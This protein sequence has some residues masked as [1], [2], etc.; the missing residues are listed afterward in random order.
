VQKQHL[1]ASID[2]RCV[3]QD[4]HVVMV[5]ST[6]FPS[7]HDLTVITTTLARQCDTCIWSFSPGGLDIFSVASNKTSVLAVHMDLEDHYCETTVPIGMDHRKLLKALRGAPKDAHVRFMYRLESDSVRVEWSS[8]DICVKN[9]IHLVTCGDDYSNVCVDENEVSLTVHMSS[10]PLVDAIECLSRSE[11]VG[12]E[13][14]TLEKHLRFLNKTIDITFPQL[15]CTMTTKTSVRISQTIMTKYIDMIQLFESVVIRLGQL[16]I[17]EGRR[18]HDMFTLYI[19][20]L[21]E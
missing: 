16:F 18:E 12:I 7:A 14:T 21:V 9:K 11:D 15:E 1:D 20:P 17:I 10:E 13:I 19:A 4:M 8:D 6:T 3:G 2:I 5:L